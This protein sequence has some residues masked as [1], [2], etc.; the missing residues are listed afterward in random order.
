MLSLCVPGQ[1]KALNILNVESKFKGR[2][3]EEKKKKMGKGF[4]MKE[5]NKEKNRISLKFDKLATNWEDFISGMK[6]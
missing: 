4:K 3:F 5:F 2:I 1:L 6:Y